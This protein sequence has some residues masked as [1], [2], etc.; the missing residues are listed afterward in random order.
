MYFG[1]FYSAIA[2]KEDLFH[3]ETLVDPLEPTDPTRKYFYAL[4][5]LARAN[6]T[7]HDVCF[8]QDEYAILLRRYFIQVLN[9]FR[10]VVSLVMS[11]LV[12][13]H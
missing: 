9:S 6:Y 12:L 5:M 3:L 2:R 1:T 10:Y 4:C 11:N 13:C 7:L 8:V